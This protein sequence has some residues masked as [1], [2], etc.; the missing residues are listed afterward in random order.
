M[1]EWVR[2]GGVLVAIGTSAVALANPD[3]ELSSNRGR[4]FGYEPRL[5]VPGETEGQVAH[6]QLVSHMQQIH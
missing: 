3:L 5:V 6:A 2:A 4:A 1:R